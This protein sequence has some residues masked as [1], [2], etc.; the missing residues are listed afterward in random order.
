MKRGS[1][2][3][4][5]AG[6]EYQIEVTIWTALDLMLA[7]ASTDTL[8]IEPPSHEDIEASI[9]N[10]DDAL[11]G[12]MAQVADRIDLIFQ[13]KTRSGSPWSSKEF[14]KILIGTANKEDSNGRQTLTPA[15]DAQARSAPA[16]RIHH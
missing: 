2:N 4:G 6:Y 13:V 1:G 15:R 9:Q 5:Y 14:A 16:I 3:P 12:L 10:P 7:K 8:N 11:L